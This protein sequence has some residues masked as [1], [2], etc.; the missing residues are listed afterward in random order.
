M[1]TNHSSQKKGGARRSDA[2][3]S[4]KRS[5]RKLLLKY[6][7]IEKQPSFTRVTSNHTSMDP[8]QLYQV[9]DYNKEHEGF[10][11][12]R[13]ND[14]GLIELTLTEDQYYILQKLMALQDFKTIGAYVN[15]AVF[16]VMKADA[17]GCF[18]SALREQALKSLEQE[19]EEK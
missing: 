8:G 18:G 17:D 13:I 11:F 6:M 3:Q 5:T 1:V 16:R 14:Y 10:P 4:S 9:Q 7:V 12:K 2:P 19:G 15:H